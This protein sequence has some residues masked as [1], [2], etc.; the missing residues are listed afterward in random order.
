M[1]KH[2]AAPEEVV[3]GLKDIMVGRI[4]ESRTLFY[5]GHEINISGFWED[6]S[7]NID[8]FYLLVFKFA[9][10]NPQEKFELVLG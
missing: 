4:K 6:V 9:I 7:I 1:E 2:A 5:R 3:H 10:Q 8:H